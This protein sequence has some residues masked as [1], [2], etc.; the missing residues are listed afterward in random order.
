MSSSV[1]NPTPIPKL[2]LTAIVKSRF[3]GCLTCI[4]FSLSQHAELNLSDPDEV[5]TS[6]IF[7]MKPSYW[8]MGDL[9]RP[10]SAQLSIYSESMSGQM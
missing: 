6:D 5:L 3:T 9:K 4:S 10:S 1:G 7:P 8:S 2:S